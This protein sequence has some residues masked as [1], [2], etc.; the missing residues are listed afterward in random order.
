MK[1]QRKIRVFSEKLKKFIWVEIE[2]NLSPD[3]LLNMSMGY[4]NSGGGSG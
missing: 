1:K 4:S 3:E 2:P